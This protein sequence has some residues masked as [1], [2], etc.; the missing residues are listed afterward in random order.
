MGG[1]GC[2]TNNTVCDPSVSQSAI[3]NVT[4]RYEEPGMHR[5]HQLTCSEGI[6]LG[7]EGKEGGGKF[8]DKGDAIEAWHR[9]L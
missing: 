8:T 2:S 1:T 7:G 3:L 5:Q 9:Q 6:R 4:M